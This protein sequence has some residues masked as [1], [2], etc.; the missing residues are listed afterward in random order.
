MDQLFNY[1]NPISNKFSI[2]TNKDIIIQ[3]IG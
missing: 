2:S 1:R 3:K